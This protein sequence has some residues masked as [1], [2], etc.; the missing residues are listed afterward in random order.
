MSS[1]L[2]DLHKH[3]ADL[4]RRLSKSLAGLLVTSE[5]SPFPLAPSTDE[6]IR[7]RDISF[8]I[9]GCLRLLRAFA[10]TP[11]LARSEHTASQSS[12]AITPRF[13]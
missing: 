6:E 8:C 5:V 12:F 2:N 4:D 9:R 1:F 11:S 10:Q 7:E 3:S 13:P